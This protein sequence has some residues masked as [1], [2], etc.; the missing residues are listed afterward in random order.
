VTDELRAAVAAG[1]LGSEDQYR[2]LLQSIVDVARAIFKAKASSILLLDE[3]ADELV[4]EAAADEASE[5]LIG[6]RFP[7]STGIAGFVLVSRQPLVIEDV[8]ADPRFSRE[9][10]ESTGFVPKGLMAVPLL[11]EER[12]LGVLEVLDRP[13]DT[14]FTL[15]EMELLGLFANQAAIALDLLQRARRAHEALRGDGELGVISRLAEKLEG[16]REE[17]SESA[18]RLLAELERLL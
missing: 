4:F 12:V 3:E 11:H 5:N 15:A 17:G 7:S 10:A 1:V 13:S 14:R 6:K 8:L 2:A 16:R 9:T 18:L